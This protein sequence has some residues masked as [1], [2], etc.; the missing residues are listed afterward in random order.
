[1]QVSKFVPIENKQPILALTLGAGGDSRA[2]DLT[3]TKKPQPRF[4]LL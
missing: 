2:H 1:M 3:K 4:V